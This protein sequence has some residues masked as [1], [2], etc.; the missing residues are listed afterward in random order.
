MRFCIAETKIAYRKLR[1]IRDA[2]LW[3]GL[4]GCLACP[5]Q[6]TELR[7]EVLNAIREAAAAASAPAPRYPVP[8]PPLPPAASLPRAG[9]SPGL[10]PGAT[11]RPAPAWTGVARSEGR[12]QADDIGLV[13]N[14]ADPYSVAVGEYYIRR[15]GLKPGQVL[16]LVLPTGTTL[17]HEEFEHLRGRINLRF[18]KKVQALALSWARPYAVECNSINGALA[19][20]FDAALCEDS[21]KPSRPSRY[22]NAATSRPFTT[23]GLRPSML[24]AAPSIESARDLIDRGALA[25]GSLAI[26]ERLPVSVML[27][28]NNSDPAR[29]VRT[30]LYPP[31]GPMAGLGVTVR[32]EPALVL[33]AARRVLLVSTGAMRLDFAGPLD[34]VPGGL[35]DHLTS[36]GGALDPWHGQST[37]MEWIASGATASHGSVSEPCNHLQKFPHPQLL[38]LHYIQGSTALEA[39]WKSVAWPQQSLFI[40]EPLAAPFAVP[41]WAR[42][43]ARPVAPPSNPST[44]PTAPPAPAPPSPSLSPL[45]LP[46]PSEPTASAPGPG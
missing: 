36:F 31:A 6:S 15:R 3:A 28:L 39:Y 8:P 38:L 20:G 43:G 12:L 16:R 19:L 25:D 40:G 42:A 10:Q 35:G 7:P 13:I 29:S 37:A 34:W 46:L 14:T 45:P 27:M 1:R 11:P 18:D 21:C 22:F 24:L 41:D 26:R 33:P 44:V 5:A 9:S 23:L 17:T 32:V 30:V 4:L 2:A